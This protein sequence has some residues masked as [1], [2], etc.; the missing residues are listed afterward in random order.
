MKRSEFLKGVFAV[1]LGATVPTLYAGRAR[2]AGGGAGRRTAVSSATLDV[3]EIAGLHF[4]REE[5]KL[6]HDVYVALYA[7]WGN[8]VFNNIAASES[9]HT[10]A[11]IN[12]LNAYGIAD[13]A[14]SNPPGVFSDASLQTLYDLLMTRGK[15][16]EVEALKVGAFIEETDMRDLEL[17][18]AQTDEAMIASVYQ[19]LLCGSRNHLR[20]FARQLTMRGVK[21]VP[22]VITQAQWDAIANSSNEICG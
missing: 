2:A 12:L 6:A 5:E 22:E 9:K 16:N 11:V 4:M 17:R 8:S 10:Q 18:I 13:T 21:Y 15:V 1:G 19:N 3:V 7:L 14:A 20:A